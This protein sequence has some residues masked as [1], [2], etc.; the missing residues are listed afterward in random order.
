M[1]TVRSIQDDIII[2]Q[3]KGYCIAEYEPLQLKSEG[4]NEREA[5]DALMIDIWANVARMYEEEV[6]TGRGHAGHS[7][8]TIKEMMDSVVFEYWATHTPKTRYKDEKVGVVTIELERPAGKPVMPI[9]MRMLDEGW[10]Y[11]VMSQ[12]P[13]EETHQDMEEE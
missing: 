12:A 10:D 13:G 2:D 11:K 1:W 7:L 3:R 6:R 9:D 8:P 4:S 5:R